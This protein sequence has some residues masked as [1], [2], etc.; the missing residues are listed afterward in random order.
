M[1]TYYDPLAAATRGA[2]TGFTVSHLQWPRLSVLVVDDA[3]LPLVGVS[4][5]VG[6]YTTLTTD[7]NGQASAQVPRT[8]YAVTYSK[9]G[10]G[11]RVAP[12][13]MDRRRDDI[14]VLSA[15][16][17]VS[18]VVIQASVVDVS[19]SGSLEN[20]E[21]AGE[22]ASG[23]TNGDMAASTDSIHGSASYA[24]IGSAVTVDETSRAAAVT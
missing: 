18:T 1:T 14:E 12:V 11:T 3:G 5:A 7:V 19:L 15:L 20:S 2:V 9:A 23:Q 10:Y 8:T 17:L 21:I 16:V 22:L 13:V 24:G 6:T 4:V